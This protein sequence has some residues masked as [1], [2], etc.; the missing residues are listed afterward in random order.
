MRILYIF[1]RLRI[2]S[3]TTSLSFIEQ[4]NTKNEWMILK[5]NRIYELEKIKFLYELYLNDIC[6]VEY[7]FKI[8]AINELITLKWNKKKDRVH[9]NEIDECIDFILNK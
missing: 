9:D 3:E 4:K 5:K 1:S 8:V 7:Y 2:L 6:F